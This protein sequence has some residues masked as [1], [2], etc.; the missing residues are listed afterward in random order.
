MSAIAPPLD[1]NALRERV[2][3]EG[4]VIVMD[5]SWAAYKALLDSVG[6]ISFPHAYHQG[7]LELMGKSRP[8][9]VY[10]WLLGRL[11]EVWV[12]ELGLPLEV[13]GEMTLQREDV[14]VPGQRVDVRR[15]S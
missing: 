5:L 7:R 6:E 4:H 1:G 8:H 2:R 3:R 14:E 10:K 11:V 9:E 15:P 12:D 13:G